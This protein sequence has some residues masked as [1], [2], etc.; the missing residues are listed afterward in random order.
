MKISDSL[1][2]ERGQIACAACG[3]ELARAGTSWKQSASVRERPVSE[4]PGAGLGVDPTVVLREFAC[5][6]CGALLDT[7]TALPGDPFLEDLPA[8]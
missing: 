6:G 2:V 3:H 1:V 4:L 8:A 5:P 7:E